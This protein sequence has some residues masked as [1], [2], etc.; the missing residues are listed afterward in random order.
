MSRRVVV[1]RCP[2]VPTAPKTA[3]T[4]TNFRSASDETMMALFPPNS[5]KERPSRPA[6][7]VATALPIRVEP[8]ADT[9]GTRGSW[10]S[11]SP[12]AAPPI[13]SPLRPSGAPKDSITRAVIFWQAK[14]VKGVFSEGFQTHALPQTQASMV[15]QLHTATGKLKAEMTPTTPKGC[16]CS[17][18]R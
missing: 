6:T 16:H 3:P 1:Q 8:V 7:A 2:A 18:I 5:N 11:H 10:L 9:K 15:F 17:Y 14:A 4:V 12:T 13:T